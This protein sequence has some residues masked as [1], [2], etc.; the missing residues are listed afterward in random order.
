MPFA[1]SKSYLSIV[2]CCRPTF[3]VIVEE[4]VAQIKMLSAEA[5]MCAPQHHPPPPA[6]PRD[7]LGSALP[8]LLDLP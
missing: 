1:F 6:P 4:I 3:E 2:D 8:A 5:A 7:P